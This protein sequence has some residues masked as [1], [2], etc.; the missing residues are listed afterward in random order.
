MGV[1]GWGAGAT[2]L[3]NEEQHVACLGKDTRPCCLANSPKK[4]DGM[5]SDSKGGQE[6]GH[7]GPRGLADFEFYASAVGSH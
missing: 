3:Q 1:G 7:E 5:Q 6:S 2:P 4:Q